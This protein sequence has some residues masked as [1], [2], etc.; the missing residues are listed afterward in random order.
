[1]RAGVSVLAWLPPGLETLLLFRMKWPM[2]EGVVC[3]G[4]GFLNADAPLP[5]LDGRTVGDFWRWAYSHVMSNRNRSL[6]AEFMVG[7]ALGVVDQPR[8]EWD[9]VDLRY[10]GAAFTPP[11]E[12]SAKFLAV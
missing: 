5:G 11:T 10:G 9:A 1:M 8:V 7:V 2:V 6:V 12:S 4:T 3:S